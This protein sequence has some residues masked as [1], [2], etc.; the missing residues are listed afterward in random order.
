MPPGC[1]PPRA[2]T[3]F[4]FENLSSEAA[5]KGFVCWDTVC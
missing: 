1:G 2:A 4:I 3:V 5:A